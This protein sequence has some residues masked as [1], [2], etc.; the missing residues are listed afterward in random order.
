MTRVTSDRE[1]LANARLWLAFASMLFVSG[2]TNVFPVFFPALLAEFGGSRGATAATA[3][4]CWIGGAVLGPIAGFLV[5]RGNP[6]AVAMTG[7]TGA[8]AGMLLGTA[9]PTL[10]AFVLA[11]GMGA[12]MG[13]GL[14]GIATQASL[15]ADIYHRRRGVAMGIAFS[16]SMAAYAV[17]PLMHSVIERSGWRTALGLYGGAVCVLIPLA[18]RILPTRL[19]S[20]PAPGTRPLTEPNPSVGQILVSPPFAMLFL[21]FTTPPMFGYLA[22]TQHALYFPARG[23]SPEEAS[24][25]LAVGGVLSAGGR[26]LAGVAADRLG[27]AP[28]GFL[29]FSLSLLGMACLFAFEAW[30]L[31]VL[32]YGYVLFLFLPLGSRA[33]IF[34]VLVSRIT[35]PAHYGVIFGILGIGNN[36]GAAAGPW[37]SGALYDRTGSYGAIYLWAAGVG[38]FGLAT[39]TA[40]VLMTGGARRT[41]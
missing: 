40:F 23:L 24:I 30:P 17:A 16:G 1:T 6:R 37:L 10:T 35:P 12:G 20:A 22:T 38:L 15:L 39:L 13:V 33:T 11:V 41:A 32:A 8:A 36:L 9:A 14:T 4:L 18:W 2:I 29:S 5:A 26:M 3:S 19:Q 7:L 31:R 21:A 34:S 28:T 27:A 25:M